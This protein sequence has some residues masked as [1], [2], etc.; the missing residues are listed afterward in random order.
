MTAIVMQT[1]ALD[2]SSFIENAPFS[3]TTRRSSFETQKAKGSCGPILKVKTGF[4]SEKSHLSFAVRE[5]W[6]GR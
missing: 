6:E 3:K 2:N 4:V 1:C 5:S